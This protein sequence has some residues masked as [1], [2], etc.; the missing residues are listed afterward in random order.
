MISTAESDY[1]WSFTTLRD[2]FPEELAQINLRIHLAARA[3]PARANTLAL[4]SSP[5]VNDVLDAA[6]S[7]INLVDRRASNMPIMDDIRHATPPGSTT[8]MDAMATPF[9]STTTLTPPPSAIDP[10]LDTSTSLVIH[11]S[12]QAVLGVFEDIS[13]SLLQSLSEPQ[14]GH[15]HGHAHGHGPTPP[16]TPPH[17]P[18][19]QTCKSQAMV[20]A[21]LM[22]HLLGE[23]DRAVLSLAGGKPP[24]APGREPLDGNQAVGGHGGDWRREGVVG[25]LW[26]E[27]ERRRV[28]VGAQVKAVE[29]LLL[30]RRRGLEVV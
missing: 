26:G 14:H 22:S 30:R 27:M 3:L 2:Y 17:A 6:Y 4:L 12:H 11:A 28:R 21:N 5:A 18:L 15:G 7:L 23:L 9:D 1:S 25:L 20:M 13:S 10:A 8:N 19:F 29:G 24:S 16:A